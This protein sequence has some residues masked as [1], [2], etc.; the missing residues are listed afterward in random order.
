MH[1]PEAL[2]VAWVQSLLAK[3]RL[4]ASLAV[5]MPANQSP[6]LFSAEV[7]ARADALVAQYPERGSA[8]LPL[9][10]LA[11]EAQGWVSDAAIE[12]V[13]GKTGFAPV[14]VLGV[15][16][17]YPM[18]R[19]EPCGRRHVR[20]CR[21][22]SCALRGAYA[23]MEALEG[24]FGVKCGAT[25]ADGAVTLEFVECLAACGSAPVVQVDHALHEGVTA[26]RVPALASAL[27]ASLG[28]A[29][30]GKKKTIPDSPEWNG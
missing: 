16:T 14:E 7:L 25:S 11:Q 1:N 19:R 26:D 27:R 23:T 29:D 6:H 8:V 10:H 20:V 4:C 15:V 30:Y 12:W 3:V 24:E 18:F 28:D 5:D 13:A 2:A 22:L 9:L 21:T 17:F